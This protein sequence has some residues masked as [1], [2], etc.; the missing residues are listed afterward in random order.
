MILLGGRSVTHA[1]DGAAQS[2]SGIIYEKV[3]GEYVTGATVILRTD[4]LPAGGT[5]PGSSPGSGTGSGTRGS[6]AGSGVRGAVSN[7]YGFFSI[8]NVPP[9]SYHLMVRTVG[10]ALYSQPIVIAPGERAPQLKIEL[11]EKHVSGDSVL[12]TADRDP[13][14]TA[15]LSRVDLRPE[16]MQKLPALGGET[17][18]FR[19]LQLLPGVKAASEISSGLYV[20]GGS[21]DQNLTLLDGVIVYNPS[22]LGGFLST[23]NSD[24]IRDIRLIKGAFPAEYGGRLSSVLDL[25]MREGTKEKITGTGGVSL[26]NS[27]L[28]IQGPIAEGSTFMLSGRRMYLDLLL[29]AL[30][31]TDRDQTPQYYFYDLNGKVNYKLSDRDHLFLSGYFGRD[32]LNSPPATDVDFGINWGN[33][34]ANLRWAHVVSPQLFTNFSAVYS[35]YSFSTLL[36]DKQN[37][38]DHTSN[39]KSVSGIRDYMLRGEAQYYPDDDHVVKA[40]IEATEHRFRADA[41]VEVNDFG[42]IDQQPTILTSLDA[43]LYAQDEWQITPRLSSN[44]GARLYYFQSG[45]YLRF[46]PRISLAYTLAEDLMLKGSFAVDNQFLHLITRNDITLPTDVWFPSTAAVKPSEAW[47]AVMGVE[48]HLFNREYLFTVEAYYKKMSNLLEYKDTAQLSILVPL[49]NSFTAG[50]GDAYGVEVFLNKQVGSFTGW[51]GYTL[52]WTSRTFGELNRGIPFPPRYDRRHDISVVLTYRLG[53]SWELGA[54]WVYGTGQAYTM[55]SGRY[56]ISTA[57]ADIP[58]QGMD[59]TQEYYARNDYTER[60]GYRLPAF[61]KLDL[62]FT[63]SFSWFSLPWQISIDVYNAYNH[64][65][66]FAQFVENRY[67]PASGGY[68]SKLV[69]ITL[70]PIIPTLGINFKF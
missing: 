49:E 19:V 53:E 9:G 47:Q 32:V 1:Q 33:S 39:F 4:S 52:A 66:V 8:A 67:D 55:P 29:L 27:R 63:H 22:H 44:I 58:V 42:R 56:S 36:V 12:V 11:E 26:I 13:A 37:M 48:T 21:P 6:A 62:N 20:R 70:F 10:F 16:M 2:L 28:T 25:T 15:S 69:R 50:S 68:G 61:H 7:R 60:N 34:T 45:N 17:D 14:P 40:G 46:E 41:S 5:A 65:N 35:D 54:T 59:D 57:T 23:F 24:A 38:Q 43:S 30:N 51:I 31:A 18:I 64:K 3:T